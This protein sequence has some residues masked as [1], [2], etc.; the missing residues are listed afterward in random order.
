[1]KGKLGE[2]IKAAEYQVPPP[3]KGVCSFCGRSFS[4]DEFYSR[5][6][7]VEFIISGMCQKCQDKT[8][9]EGK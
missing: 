6:N 9:E 2:L 3:T 4:S 5:I 1:M 8:L 7:L